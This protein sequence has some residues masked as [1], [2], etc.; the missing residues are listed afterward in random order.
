[1]SAAQGE[2]IRNHSVHTGAGQISSV[3][4]NTPLQRPIHAVRV[5]DLVSG[6]A[7]GASDPT[8]LLRCSHSPNGDW[9]PKL[10]KGTPSPWGEGGVR[11]TATLKNP[12]CPMRYRNPARA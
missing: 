9:L 6:E 12:A 1:M 4:I 2:R 5:R 10:Q 7:V 3:L 11:G 8:P